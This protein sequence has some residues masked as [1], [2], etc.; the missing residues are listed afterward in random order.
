MLTGDTYLPIDRLNLVNL[1]QG[2]THGEGG[3]GPGSPWDL[4]N[5]IFS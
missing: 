3:E 5:T 2:R 4:K 1:R